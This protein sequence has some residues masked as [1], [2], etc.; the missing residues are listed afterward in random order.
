VRRVCACL[1][2]VGTSLCL[3]LRPGALTVTAKIASA[4]LGPVSQR[5]RAR[6]PT[7]QRKRRFPNNAKLELDPPQSHSCSN[8]EEYRNS[9]TRQ[10]IGNSS[11]AFSPE[12]N[13]P[14]ILRRRPAAGALLPVGRRQQGSQ[15]PRKAARD[16]ST[17]SPMIMDCIIRRVVAF[18]VPFSAS[19]CRC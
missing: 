18:Q 4:R 8:A 15:T 14:F 5:D 7:F 10:S 11:R 13:Q 19:Y 6:V 9:S 16:D 17:F 1:R 12:P 3:V 2:S